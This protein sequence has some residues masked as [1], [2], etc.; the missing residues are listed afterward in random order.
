MWELGAL[1]KIK[2]KNM[3]I[4][5]CGSRRFHDD[6]R[7]FEKK[8]CEKGHIVLSPILNRNTDINTLIQGKVYMSSISDPYQPVEKELKLTKSI[9]EN[10]DKRTNLS[11]QT[12][13]DL[14]LRDIDIFKKFKNIEV[15][16]TINT[17]NKKEKSFF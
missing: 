15:G 1:T 7:K 5:I 13:S 4:V 16:F 10:L 14:V 6:I 17:F 11:I 8:L 3:K 9:L 2:I 12:K